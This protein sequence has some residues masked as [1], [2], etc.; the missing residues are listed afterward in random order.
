MESEEGEKG[1]G[2]GERREGRC[3]R[4]RVW[5]SPLNVLRQTFGVERLT[6]VVFGVRRLTFYVK[7]LALNVWR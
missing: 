1:R 2:G 7:R 5:R 6:Q 3:A 4:R